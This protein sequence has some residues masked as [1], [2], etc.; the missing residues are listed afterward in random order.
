MINVDKTKTMAKIGTSCN[1]SI[2]GEQ[3]EQ[4]HE[5]PYLGSLITDDSECT[6]EIHTRLAKG[7]GMGSKLKK[8]WQSHVMAFLHPQK[9]GF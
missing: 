1:I 8:I 7:H 9:S 5:F 2:N 4:V 3:L 6:R